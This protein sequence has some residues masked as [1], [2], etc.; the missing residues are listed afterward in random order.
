VFSKIYLDI[1][2]QSKNT[3]LVANFNIHCIC[4]PIVLFV[5]FFYRLV[6][7]TYMHYRREGIYFQFSSFVK[8]RFPNSQQIFGISALH[9]AIVRKVSLHIINDTVF[10]YVEQF[11][12]GTGKP[13]RLHHCY[14]GFL[15]V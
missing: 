14:C 9:W 12:H 7:T 13:L 15:F 3:R 6:F 2:C 4:V 11:C 1:F 10:P 8:E 5:S